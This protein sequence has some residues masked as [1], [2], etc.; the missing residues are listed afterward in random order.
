MSVNVSF[1][2]FH[3]GVGKFCVIEVGD[4]LV[5]V[6]IECRIREIGGEILPFS[7][8][9]PKVPIFLGRD[10]KTASIQGFHYRAE[11]YLPSV[12]SSDH[13]LLHSGHGL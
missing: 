10:R 13:E 11:A 2:F 3:S 4:S 8:I 5:V 1:R 9:F 12:P 6:T 7:A